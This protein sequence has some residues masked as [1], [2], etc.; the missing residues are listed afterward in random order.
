MAYTDY[1]FEARRL[2]ARLEE[3]E[4][5]LESSLKAGYWLRFAGFLLMVAFALF[6]LHAV[7]NA[8]DKVT[9]VPAIICIVGALFCMS[10]YAGHASGVSGPNAMRR[11]ATRRRA[12]YH[13]RVE[14]LLTMEE[15]K[16]NGESM[17]SKEWERLNAGERE[18]AWG[19]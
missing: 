8:G 15:K 7:A 5:D 19:W 12:E 9:G 3:A 6:F 10:L 2:L 17:S 18:D 13:D 11:R 4:A 1:D 16:K 14:F